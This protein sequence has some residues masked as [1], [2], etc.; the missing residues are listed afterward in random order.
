MSPKDR[1]DAQRHN[2]DPR[3]RLSEII[4]R[5][6]RSKTITWR[7]DRTSNN[8]ALN[9]V[10]YC[11]PKMGETF[12][13]W[14]T[15]ARGQLREDIKLIH[16]DRAGSESDINYA[17]LLTSSL[18]LFRKPD[19]FFA[20]L[21][22]NLFN[23]YQRLLNRNTASRIPSWHDETIRPT[24]PST[25]PQ[26][27]ESPPHREH[28]RQ[29]D[30]DL[31]RL[32]NLVQEIKNAFTLDTTFEFSK[33]YREGLLNRFAD[34][35][36]KT[37]NSEKNK[38]FSE[39][40]QIIRDYAYKRRQSIEQQLNQELPAYQKSLARSKEG[41]PRN[42]NNWYGCFNKILQLAIEVGGYPALFKGD[43]SQINNDL[44]R[45]FSDFVDVFINLAT[46]NAYRTTTD[47]SENSYDPYL[48]VME[49][50][51]FIAGIVGQKG[52]PTDFYKS[53]FGQQFGA[54]VQQKKEEMWRLVSTNFGTTATF[55]EVDFSRYQRQFNKPI[56]NWDEFNIAV[57]IINELYYQWLQISDNSFIGYNRRK[58]ELIH[59]LR[60]NIHGFIEAEIINLQSASDAENLYNEL[61]KLSPFVIFPFNP[62]AAL[63]KKKLLD[64]VK[65][66]ILNLLIKDLKVGVGERARRFF[67][68]N[69]SVHRIISI[70]EQRL[71]TVRHY[72]KQ[73]LIN[74]QQARWVC[75][76]LNIPYLDSHS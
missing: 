73:G 51:R 46:K 64:R 42:F 13:D 66:Y 63:E 26:H 10:D 11:P 36:R 55:E 33:D 6:I 53:E 9:I 39:T 58:D 61:D 15:R 22:L 29:S 31:A 56:N 34:Q 21:F 20:R 70:D 65:D 2:E 76:E 68:R 16:P 75:E 35:F 48:L 38:I 14:K 45:F 60:N 41:Q 27:R 57:E 43:Q 62:D 18:D 44:L 50:D 47:N 28:S 69:L 40:N 12:T 67:K 3:K 59:K 17:Q 49:F 1:L 30:R 8:V 52:L 32:N 54:I 24:R 74:Q 4:S 7:D 5:I 23:E 37:S 71:M 19:Q 25:R 72:L